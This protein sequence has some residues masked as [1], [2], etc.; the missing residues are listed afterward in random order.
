MLFIL[1]LAKTE[2]VYILDKPNYSLEQYIKR[3]PKRSISLQERKASFVGI[4]LPNQTHKWNNNSEI[5]TI[6]GGTGTINSFVWKLGT[7][8]IMALYMTPI[9][10]S[11]IKRGH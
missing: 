7:V 1:S 8:M 4:W 5:I 11:S 3:A 6:S 10:T 9:Y 2:H